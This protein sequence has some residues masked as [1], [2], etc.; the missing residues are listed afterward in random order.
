MKLLKHLGYVLSLACT[1]AMIGSGAVM[2]NTTRG[3][4]SWYGPGFHNKCVAYWYGKCEVFNQNL[5]TAA[6]PQNQRHLLNTCARVTNARNGESV[7]VRIN[8][9]GSFSKYGRVMDLSKAAFDELGNLDSGT[10]QVQI[11]Y[12]Q[13]PSNCP[14]WR[15]RGIQTR[16]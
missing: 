11:A 10:M 16:S 8:D 5:L 15:G 9:T 14:H 2:A 12:N 3:E 6:V 7:Y 13:D 1:I 4:A